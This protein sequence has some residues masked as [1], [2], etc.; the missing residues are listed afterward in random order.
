MAGRNAVSPKRLWAPWRAVFLHGPKPRGCIFCHAGGTPRQD[1]KNLVVA[2]S[3][4]AFAMLN[5][6]PYNNG[7]VMIAPARHVGATDQLRPEE[8]LAVLRLHQRLMPKLKRHLHPH[9]FNIGINQGR[10]AGAG[11]LG[12]MHLHVVPRW[13][14]DVNFMPIAGNTKVI[15]QSLD[16]LYR[17]LTR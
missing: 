14:G 12:H 1:R 5:L 2:R 15:S 9:G 7:H 11:I 4:H 16:E 10:A 13:V 8:W 6:Y 3:R 17:L